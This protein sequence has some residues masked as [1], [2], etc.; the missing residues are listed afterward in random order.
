MKPKP[1]LSVTAVLLAWGVL[2]SGM[3]SGCA[4]SVG[5]RKGE[6][7]HPPTRGQELID[8]KQARDQGVLSEEEYQAQR[9]K[10]LKQ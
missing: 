2:L 7:I 8:L 5:E 9:Q 4:W 1:I 10:L 3:L 6:V